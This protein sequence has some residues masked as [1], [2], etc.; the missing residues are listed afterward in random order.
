MGRP[1]RHGPAGADI[2]Y[3]FTDHNGDP[4]CQISARGIPV[5]EFSGSNNSMSITHNDGKFDVTVPLGDASAKALYNDSD[6]SYSVTFPGKVIKA[7]GNA[8]IDGNTVTWNNY[9]EE[10]GDLHAVG[11]DSPD[12]RTIPSPA[13]RAPPATGRTARTATGNSDE[14]VNRPSPSHD[15]AR[16]AQPSS[17]L[18]SNPGAEGRHEHDRRIVLPVSPAGPVP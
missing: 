13:A 14:S 10:N 12:R 1:R 6:S 9:L 4:A 11:K 18:R 16:S 7:S 15:R 2:T 5:S 3:T 8:T 17:R